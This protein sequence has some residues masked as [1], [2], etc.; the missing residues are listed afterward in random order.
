MVQEKERVKEWV[1]V[2]LGVNERE[3]FRYKDQKLKGQSIKIM[4]KI[5]KVK[6][7]ERTI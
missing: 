1:L 7:G 2:H 6:D 3:K 4:D 5:K